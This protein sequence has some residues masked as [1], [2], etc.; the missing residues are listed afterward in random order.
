MQHYSNQPGNTSRLVMQ[1]AILYNEGSCC[2]EQEH[3]IKTL[4]ECF[5][6]MLPQLWI[7]GDPLPLLDLVS[8]H[9]QE[10]L[11]HMDFNR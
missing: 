9:V 2:L 5:W 7:L 4:G 1:E 6:T 3:R 11:T 10:S 8:C